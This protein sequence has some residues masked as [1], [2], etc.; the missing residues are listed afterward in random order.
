VELNGGTLERE[1]FESTLK[2][3]DEVEFLYFMGGR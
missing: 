3:G 1:K 2:V